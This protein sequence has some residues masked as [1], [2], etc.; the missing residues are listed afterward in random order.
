[1]GN[2]HLF[3]PIFVALILEMVITTL[4]ESWLGYLMEIFGFNDQKMGIPV[5]WT[6]L[7][8]QILYLKLSNRL[9]HAVV[10]PFEFI[11]AIRRNF[12]RA[13][14]NPGVLQRG[15]NGRFIHG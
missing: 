10:S 2:W 7:F 15:R 1:M 3:K 4:Y 6:F 12:Q 11:N 9:F 13:N 14:N 8:D 5:R